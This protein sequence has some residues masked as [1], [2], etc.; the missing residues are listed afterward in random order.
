MPKIRNITCVLSL[1]ERR[2]VYA[3]FAKPKRPFMKK[4][5][6][7]KINDPIQLCCILI[8]MFGPFPKNKTVIAILANN[9]NDNRGIR[10]P[11]ITPDIYRFCE[12]IRNHSFWLPL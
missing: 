5:T 4:L 6:T 10:T 3:V 12:T 2:A 1:I 7:S 9:Q 11:S 8:K